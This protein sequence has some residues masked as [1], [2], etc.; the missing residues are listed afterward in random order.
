MAGRIQST[1]GTPA[2]FDRFAAVILAMVVLASVLPC[3]GAIAAALSKLT[4]AA[5]VLLFFLHGARL[6]R[7]AILQA[8]AHWRL[9]VL[10]LATTFVFFPLVGLALQP[11]ARAW[12]GPSL[13]AGMLFLCAVPSTVQSSIAFTSLAK[14]N[15]AA[16]VCSAAAS[17]VLAVVLTPLLVRVLG[18]GTGAHVMS[19][20]VAS[21]IVLQLLL[22][23][24]AGH[25]SQRRLAGTLAR[26]ADC[27]RVVDQSSIA[28]AVYTSFSAAALGGL[29][30][31]VSPGA[32]CALVILTACLLALALVATCQGSRCL[33]FT[34]KDEIVVVFCGSK[35]SLA[36]GVPFANVLFPAPVVGTMLL[37]LMIFHQIQLMVCAMIAR[38]YAQSYDIDGKLTSA[39]SLSS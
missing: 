33:G 21:N 37:P 32:L 26:H 22:P 14:G 8:A 36:S 29:W 23:F 15:V 9:H 5:I 27:L 1:A 30:H 6:S 28:L 34:R 31:R 3:R 4:Y 20:P 13:A 35:K 10:V 17:S 18:L 2:K 11:I 16:A 12:I 25:V 19:A 38:H 39:R 24:V 7:D